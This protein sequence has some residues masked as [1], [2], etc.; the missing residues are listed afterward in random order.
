MLLVAEPK[1]SPSKELRTSPTMLSFHSTVSGPLEKSHRK[2]LDLLSE[3]MHI[4]IEI[5][6]EEVDPPHHLTLVMPFDWLELKVWRALLRS[7]AQLDDTA[8]HAAIDATFFD[9]ETGSKHYRRRINNRALTL[10]VTALVNTKHKLCLTSTAR[11]R[12]IT[13]RRST[14]N[15]PSTTRAKLPASLLTEAT[16]DGDHV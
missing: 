6:L 5:I 2:A 4:L 8:D 16:T 10:K 1:W 14:G 12:N 3:M 15:S 13:T 9:Y 7:S 11:Q